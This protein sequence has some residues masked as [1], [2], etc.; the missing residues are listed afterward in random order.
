MRPR[1]ICRGMV[2]QDYL[3]DVD[4][5]GFN[6]AP[7]NLP[8]N[9]AKAVDGVAAELTASMRPRQICRGMRRRS[10]IDRFIIALLQ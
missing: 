1:Q 9:D 8:G 5:E 4:I 2:L 10:R 3:D 7:A 6:E